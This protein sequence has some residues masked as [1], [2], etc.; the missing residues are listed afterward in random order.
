MAIAVPPI[1]CGVLYV[2]QPVG[3]RLRCYPISAGSGTV[4]AGR[5]TQ[6]R[7]PVDRRQAVVSY[8]FCSWWTGSCLWFVFA[9]LSFFSIFI[10]FLLCSRSSVEDVAS[11]REIAFEKFCNYLKIVFG[12]CLLSLYFYS[13]CFFVV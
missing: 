12:P 9:V 13:F 11:C 10:S 4:P 7:L 6:F 5:F 3:R 1:A 2:L 8:T